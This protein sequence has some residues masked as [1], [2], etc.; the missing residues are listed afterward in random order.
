MADARTLTQEPLDGADLAVMDRRSSS[1][2]DSL[3]NSLAAGPGPGTQ[4]YIVGIGASAG[5]LEAL[6]QF[7]STMSPNSGLTFVIVQHLSPDFKSLM[8]EI[9]ARRTRIPIT[10]AE[11]GMALH[12]NHIYLNTPR[13][14]LIVSGRKFVLHEQEARTTLHLPIDMLFQS[15]AQDVGDHAIGI[16]L[17]GTGSDGARGVRAIK[18]VGGLVIVQSEETAKFD[19][20]PHSA[21]ATGMADYILSPQEIPARLL[22]YIHHPWTFATTAQ[23]SQLVTEEEWL[24]HIFALLHKY[25][26]IDF[27]QYKYSTI[28]RRLQRRMV[29]NHIETFAE[30]VIHLQNSPEE[31]SKLAEDLLISVTRFFRDRE[32]FSVL[33]REVI[34]KIV[35]SATPEV[36]IRIWVAGCATGEEAYSIAI[37]F[38]EQ[39]VRSNQALRVKIFA[40]DVDDAALAQASE[41]VF[42]ESIAVDISPQR[43]AQFFVKTGTHYVIDRHIREMI[44]FTTHDLT[45]NPPFTKVDLVSCRN[46]LIYFETQLQQKVLSL[47]HF[48]LNPKGILFLGPSESLGALTEEFST[49]DKKWKISQKRRRSRLLLSAPLGQPQ[50]EHAFRYTSLLPVSKRL[51]PQDVTIQ[52][53]YKALIHSF[54][55]PA[56]LVNQASEILHVFGDAGKFLSIRPGE[57][58]LS[59]TQ[60]VPP[61]LA[62]SLSTALHKASKIAEPVVYRDV[63]V[64]LGN[65]VH[66]IDLRVQ[67]LE[68]GNSEELYLLVFFIESPLPTTAS[69]LS[70]DAPDTGKYL[71]QRVTDL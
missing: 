66:T 62:I 12:P 59:I 6:E 36:P 34:P 4:S 49:V 23:E 71:L 21:V 29:I 22:D 24:P 43:L 5:G 28:F 27:S 68:K 8:A 40:T 67:A 51:I 65:E 13:T 14:N 16:V 33:E 30:Y 31:V 11:H 39:I 7:F 38:Q 58:S 1:T 37:L 69:S 42:S 32:A 35:A 47:L 10:R 9:L 15:I 57:P 17:S 56:V 52:R 45:T 25:S 70:H 48:A 55:P 18:E 60:L 53:A 50:R 61:D 3:L 41:G 20:M 54:A 63:H 19:G 26:S 46:L 64:G 2:E 44:L